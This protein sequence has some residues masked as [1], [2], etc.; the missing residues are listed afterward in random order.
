VFKFQMKS[1]CE[2][3]LAEAISVSGE[4]I[5]STGRERRFRNDTK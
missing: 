5:A 4:E 2:G 3:T 1:H